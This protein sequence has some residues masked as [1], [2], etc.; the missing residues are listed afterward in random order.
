MYLMSVNRTHKASKLTPA[1]DAKPQIKQ[2]AFQNGGP[3]CAAV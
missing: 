3:L 1:S 2:Y